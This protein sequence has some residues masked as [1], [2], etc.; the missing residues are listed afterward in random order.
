MNFDFKTYM[1]KYLELNDE[2]YNQK[3]EVIKNRFNSDLSQW[4]DVKTYIS[5]EEKNRIETVGEKIRSICDVFVVIGIGGSYMGSKAVIEALLP[6]YDR[7]KPEIIFLGINL[8]PDY[9]N[10]TLNYIKDKDI[11]VNVISKS[12][13]TLEPSLAFDMVLKIMREKYSEEELQ[14][15]VYITTDR[16]SGTLRR[17]VNE[18]GY[19]SFEVPRNVGGRFSVFT[20]VGLLPL[21][22]AG[23]DLDDFLDGA[24]VGNNY[25]DDA[26]KYARIRDIML[27]SNRYI[28]STT[29]Y[30][31]KLFYFTEWVKQLFAE[32]QGKNNSGIMPITSLNSRD[33]HS[34]GQY[35]QQGSPIVFETVIGVDNES[36]ISIDGSKLTLKDINDIVRDR[37]LWHTLMVI[38]LVS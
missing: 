29:V 8:D 3:D 32:T 5:E 6:L 12:G 9:I 13:N 35:F 38:H 11:C 27:K 2:F 21:K 14:D 10:E 33:L 37:L 16:E 22:V 23:I 18:K 4:L 34:I 30:H 25:L 28:E 17:L 20:P 36:D 19:V 24:K 31:F 1:N 26:F 15:R 7:K